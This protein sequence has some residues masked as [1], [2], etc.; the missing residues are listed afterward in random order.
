MSPRPPPT[1][2][3]PSTG[4]RTPATGG[5]PAPRRPSSSGTRGRPSS[6][7][8]LLRSSAAPRAAAATPPPGASDAEARRLIAMIKKSIRKRFRTL[9]DAF[10][11]FDSHHSGYVGKE[12]IRDAIRVFGVPYVPDGVLDKIIDICDTD[13]K[14]GNINFHGACVLERWVGW[15]RRGPVFGYE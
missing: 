4:R 13:V 8:R 12:E 1:A 10:L 6:R 14:D 2:R 3:P 9:G 7:G 5:T 15:T 11:F